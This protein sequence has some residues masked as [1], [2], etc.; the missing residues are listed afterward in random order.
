MIPIQTSGLCIRYSAK[1]YQVNNT[2]CQTEIVHRSINAKRNH[3]SYGSFLPNR[4]KDFTKTCLCKKVPHATW[5]LFALSSQHLV[6]FCR[7]KMGGFHLVPSCFNSYL[8]IEI[9]IQLQYFHRSR[10]S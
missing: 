1:R 7:Q 10:I 2:L 9:E 6:P 5:Y 3:V 4:L 8:R